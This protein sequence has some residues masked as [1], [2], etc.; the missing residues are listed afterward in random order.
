MRTTIDLDD[1]VMAAT[2]TLAAEKGLSL[3]AAL[4]ELARRGLR[5]ESAVSDEDLPVFRVPADAAPITPE[6]VR[7]ANEDE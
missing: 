7:Q 3:G 6:M 5:G 4:S 2:R 1:D